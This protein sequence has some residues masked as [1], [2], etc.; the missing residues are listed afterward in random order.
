MPLTR[1]YQLQIQPNFYKLEDLRYNAN[2]YALY[3]QHFVTQLYYSV[4]RFLSTKGMGSLANQAQ[5]E[6]MAIIAGEMPQRI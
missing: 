2:R 4:K 1:S 6:A 5:K 3:L